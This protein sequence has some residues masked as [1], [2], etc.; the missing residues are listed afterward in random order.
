MN[1]T[2]ARAMRRRPATLSGR[3]PKPTNARMIA[4]APRIPVI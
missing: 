4:S 1:R 3:L 2:I